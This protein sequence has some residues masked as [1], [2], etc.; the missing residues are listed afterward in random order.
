MSDPRGPS[1]A[2]EAIR[3]DIRPRCTSAT[4][5]RRAVPAPEP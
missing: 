3:T 5:I 1:H 4:A 2:R